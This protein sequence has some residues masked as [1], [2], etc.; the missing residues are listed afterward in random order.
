MATHASVRQA[1][2]V[3]LVEVLLCVGIVA[4]LLSI[5]LPSVAGVRD[6]ARRTVSCSNLR[7]IYSTFGIYANDSDGRYPAVI[8]GRMFQVGDLVWIG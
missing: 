8:E 2:E 4:I 7:Q 3:T 6:A 5:L 1:R